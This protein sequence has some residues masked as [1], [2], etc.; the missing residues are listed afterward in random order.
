MLVEFIV[1]GFEFYTIRYTIEQKYSL[2]LE[3]RILKVM[4]NSIIRLKLIYIL[5]HEVVFKT[6]LSFYVEETMMYTPLIFSIP[7]TFIKAYETM[8]LICP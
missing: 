8:K 7:R 1:M 5:S 4:L 6:H 3:M 2:S